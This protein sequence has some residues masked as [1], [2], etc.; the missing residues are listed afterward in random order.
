MTDSGAA[1]PSHND[2]VRPY[3]PVSANPLVIPKPPAVVRRDRTLSKMASMDRMDS[4]SFP[5]DSSPQEAPASPITFPRA[6]SFEESVRDSVYV[7]NT[8]VIPPQSPLMTK[9]SAWDFVESIRG[10]EQMDE[11]LINLGV[12]TPDASGQQDPQSE[13]QSLK[14]DHYDY[15]NGRSWVEYLFVL[16][17]ALVI[18][19]YGLF[20]TLDPAAAPGSPLSTA[21]AQ[22]I[23]QTLYPFFQDVHVMIFV[24]FGFLMTFPKT[25]RWTAL[26]F[27]FILS[28]WA[29]QW[30]ILS[31]GFWNQVI[32]GGS[33]GW[34]KVEL[35]LTSLINGDFDAAAAMITFGVLLGKCNLTQI[36]VLVF[37][38]MILCGLNEAICLQYFKA[39]DMGGSIVLH[40]FGA[41]FGLAASYFFQPKKA[42]RNP[43][44]AGYN[45]QVVALVGTLFLWMYWP[46][47][48]GALAVGAAQHRAVLNTVLSIGAG[49]LGAVAVTRVLLGR[50]EIEVVLNATLAGGVVMGSACD[51]IAAPWAALLIGLGGG[52]LSAI[53]FRLIGPFLNHHLNLQ[54]TCGVHSLHGMPG[55]M[56]AIVSGIAVA[57]SGNQGFPAGYFPVMA[58][59]G[60]LGG[61]V[62]AQFYALLTTL[63]ISIAGGAVGGYVCGL[64]V[65]RPVKT[66]YQDSDHFVAVHID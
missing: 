37:W 5:Q 61:Q 38:E 21:A 22:E 10:G 36:G 34:T 62:A 3:R 53:G 51:I 42:A 20:V 1:A 64:P 26:T 47:F 50:L 48:N 14:G 31:S 54:D 19:L 41:Y 12:D 65:F 17:E 43:P 8:P 49:C 2:Y 45:S 27:N 56:G 23:V 39:T 13:S 28:I 15:P 32:P 18:L 55:I 7:P 29:L 59:G 63:G 16:A 60:T 9:G 66:L 30:G 57:L 24:G 4:P 11:H 35:S 25:H 46:S 33:G 44:D 40:T 52:I 58:A 6:V